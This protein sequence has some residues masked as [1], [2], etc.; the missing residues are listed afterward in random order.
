M[1]SDVYNALKRK[2]IEF[3]DASGSSPNKFDSPAKVSGNSDKQNNENLEKS[4]MLKKKRVSDLAPKY[5]KVVKEMNLLKGNINFTNE[6][7]DTCKSK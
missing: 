4:P 6:I 7:M 2:G 3:P 1:F 5:Q